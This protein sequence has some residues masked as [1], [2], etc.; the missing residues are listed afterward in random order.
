MLVD[1]S[2]LVDGAAINADICIVGAGLAGIALATRLERTGM[3]IALLE[4][5]PVGTSPEADDLSVGEATEHPYFDFV[6]A[7]PRRLGGAGETWGAWCRPL[8]PLDLEARSWPDSGW[9]IELGEMQDYFAEAGDFLRLSDCGFSGEAWAEGL[10]PLYRHIQE[11][12]GLEIGVW[13]ESPLAPI[14][15]TY[16][17]LLAA[18]E[19][20]SVYLGATALDLQLDGD[21][22]TVTGIKA[23]TANGKRFAVSARHFVLAGGALGTVRLLLSSTDRC[24]PG[25]GNERG[26]VGRYFAEHPHIVGGRIPLQHRSRRPRFAAID[27]GVLGTLARV[28]MER[29]GAGI[30]AGIHL[31]EDVRRREDL[32]NVIAHLRPPSVEPPRCALVFFREVRHRNLKK[33]IKAFPGLLR[34][35]PEVVTVVYRRLLKRPAELELYVQVETTPNPDSRIVLSD[36]KD[37]FGT[38]RAEMMWR[39]SDFDKQQ[40]RRTLELIGAELEAMGLGTLR[41]EPWVTHAGEFWSSEPFG[42]LHLMGTTRMSDSPERGVVD[43]NCRVHGV[44]NLWVA[45][46]SIFPTYGA[47]NPGMTI[48][49]TALRTADRIA[50]VAATA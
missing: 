9:P 47:A 1:A 28:E 50:K 5:G 6:E 14:S 17:D 41:L 3:R 31:S 19:N 36:E 12:T 27:R 11:A 13:Q 44:A 10:P 49:A 4:S 33:A 38:P 7:A 25:V 40:L 45:G 16:A 37:A 39:I 8:D 22:T 30:R 23:G 46:S 29:P 43:A 2:E 18:S 26:L 21:G 24:K 48:V 35:I 15:E 34:H 42:G 20:I 32:P